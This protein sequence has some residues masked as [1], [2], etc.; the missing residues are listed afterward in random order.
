MPF[1]VFQLFVIKI[2]VVCGT[3]SKVVYLRMLSFVVH[4]STTLSL[5]LSRLSLFFPVS[6]PSLLLPP[7]SPSQSPPSFTLSISPS[8]PLSPSSFCLSLFTSLHPL[9]FHLS[10]YLSMSPFLIPSLCLT[11]ST[12]LSPSISHSLSPSLSIS[13]PYS[14]SPLFLSLYPP[15]SFLL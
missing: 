1:H 11:I 13:P 12:S 7:L 8:F 15:P 14:L 4:F 10:C 9:S 6:I 5:F 2:A 3:S